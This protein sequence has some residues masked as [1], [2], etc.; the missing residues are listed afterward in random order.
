VGLEIKINQKENWKDGRREDK[1]QLEI[2]N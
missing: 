1:S 2:F